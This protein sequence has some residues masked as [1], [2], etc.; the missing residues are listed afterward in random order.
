MSIPCGE[1]R[2][3]PRCHES[4][5]RVDYGSQGY[6]KTCWRDYNREAV[7]LRSARRL[8]T[9]NTFAG[10]ADKLEARVKGIDLKIEAL[11]NEKAYVK[12]LLIDLIAEQKARLS[13][14]MTDSSKIAD[15]SREELA[16]QQETHNDRDSSLTP[17][18]THNDNA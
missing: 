6:C 16:A 4:I 12:Q 1:F 14:A 7:K 8:L 9:S 11:N 2:K 5:K 18:E 3:C 17:L 10:K 15:Y 13:E